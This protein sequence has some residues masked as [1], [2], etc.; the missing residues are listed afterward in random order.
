MVE[1]VL[2]DS[3]QKI[4]QHLKRQGLATVRELTVAL[5]LSENAVRHQLSRL[6]REG[7]VEV[8]GQKQHKGRPATT[9]MLTEAAEGL[10]PKQ[11]REL[12]EIVL[13]EAKEQNV[14]EPVIDGVARRFAEQLKP[15]LAKLSAEAKVRHLRDRLDIG[16]MLFLETTPIGWELKAYNCL[17]KAAG[18]KFEAVWD[19]V[20][21]VLELSLETSVERPL[22]QRDG[23]RSCIFTIAK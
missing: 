20:P 2:M 12:L 15:E 9:F 19:L 17:Y 13:L 1:L 18:C 7:F 11:Y 23:E 8:G 14:L 4:I 3:R 21:K 5:G 16:E 22:C 10:F 6:E